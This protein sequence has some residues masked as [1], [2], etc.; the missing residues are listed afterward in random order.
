MALQDTL[1]ELAGNTPAAKNRVDLLLDKLHREAPADH[2]TLS[3]ALHDASLRAVVLTKAIRKEYG[4]AT[5]T[6]TSVSHWRRKNNAELT[7]L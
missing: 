5:V 3:A 6:D 2:A 1:T 7:G 4:I